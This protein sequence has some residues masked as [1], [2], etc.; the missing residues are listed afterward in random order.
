MGLQSF[1]ATADSPRFVSSVEVMAWRGALGLQAA[2][3]YARL[4]DGALVALH[5]NVIYR[6]DFSSR[7]FALAGA[8]LTSAAVGSNG[9]Q[10]AWN[11]EVELGARFRRSEIFA[12]VRQYDFESFGFRTGDLGPDSPAVYAGVRYRIRE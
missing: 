10:G 3:D 4:S 9:R 7:V 5:T 12:R 2:V 11:A 6:H 8:G 1:P